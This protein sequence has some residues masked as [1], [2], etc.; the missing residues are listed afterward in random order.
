MTPLG[1][2]NLRKRLKEKA[3]AIHTYYYYVKFYGLREFLA[4]AP[5]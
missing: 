5:Q 3:A 4:V 2:E 1:R